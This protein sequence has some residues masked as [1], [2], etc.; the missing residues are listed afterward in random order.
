MGTAAF[1]SLLA[2]SCFGFIYLPAGYTSFNH[3]N[4]TFV[5]E[6][7]N[8][9]YIPFICLFLKQFCVMS[10][11]VSMV[12]RLVYCVCWFHINI[13]KSIC[14]PIISERAVPQWA[15]FIQVSWSTMPFQNEYLSVWSQSA[16]KSYYSH[17]TKMV[18]R[19]EKCISSFDWI[20]AFLILLSDLSQLRIVTFIRRS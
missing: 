4:V 7:R 15:F 16:R 11:L 17:L 3:K 10:G 2:I 9:A 8:L 14:F 20:Y 13:R 1:L 5:L 18:Q 19:N 12:I 6:N